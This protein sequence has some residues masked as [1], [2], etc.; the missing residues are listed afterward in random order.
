MESPEF[1]QMVKVQTWPAEIALLLF[2]SMIIG[3]MIMR[4]R[5]AM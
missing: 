1:S 3:Y 5:N 4:K 2:L